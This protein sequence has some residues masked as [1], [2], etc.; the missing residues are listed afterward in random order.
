VQ[1]HSG[2]GIFQYAGQFPAAQAIDIPLSDEALQFYKSGRPFLNNFM[3]FWMAA[4][5]VRLLVVL[6]PLIGVLYPLMRF[7]PAVYD[8]GMR[9]R[10]TRIYGELRFLEA[11]METRGTQFDPVEA[12]ERLDRLERQANQLKMPIA[13]A[14]ML[15]L[16]RNHIA[17]VRNRLGAAMPPPT[18]A[19]SAPPPVLAASTAPHAG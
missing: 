5:I 15:Y 6:I 3:P 10:I 19:A 12:A 7:M 2:P 13:Y 1:I 17:L 18:L 11:E 14:S 8:W 16:L 4:L 9:R